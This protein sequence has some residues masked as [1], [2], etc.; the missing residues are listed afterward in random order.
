MQML[1]CRSS[2]CS[3]SGNK[4]RVPIVRERSK[5]FG[6]IRSER[7]LSIKKDVLITGP[8]ACGKTRW[9]AKLHEHAP[10]IWIGRECI[11]LRGL[12]PLQSWYE[13]PRVVAMVQK[14]GRDWAKLKSHERIDA[15]KEWVKTTRAVVMLDDAHKLAGRKLDIA[16]HLCREAGRLIVGAFAE[17][18]IPMS[19]RILIDKRDPQR[20]GL[21]S[22]AAYDVTNLAMWLAILAAIGAGWW[23]LAMVLGG[24]KVLA[25]GRSAAKQS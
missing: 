17:N 9:L 6:P 13:D 3:V 21:A 4:R 8:N 11:T 23:Q 5:K 22:E 1:M 18:N 25:T 20:V 10:E 15:L 19:L 12:E 16:L 7:V 14:A 24:M 2:G